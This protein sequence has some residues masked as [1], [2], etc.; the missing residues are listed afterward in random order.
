[1]PDFAFLPRIQVN[2][3]GS[4]LREDLQAEAVAYPLM[5]KQIWQDKIPDFK[6]IDI[7]C[8]LVGSYSNSLHSAG[9]FR[10]WR[11]IDSQAKWLRVH[12]S[13]EWP[14]YYNDA[15]KEDLRSFFDFYLRGVANTWQ[16]TPRVRYA[17]HDFDGNDRVNQISSVFP[18]TG[19][20]Y[21]KYYL[22]GSPLRRLS[23][24]PLAAEIAVQYDTQIY[25]QFAS[26]NMKFTEETVIVGYPKAHLWVE[27]KNANDMDLFV[28]LQKLDARGNHLSQFVVPNQGSIMQDL[29]EQGASIVR[30]KGP[31][32]RL[33]ASVRRLDEELSTDEIPVHSYDTIE[34][35]QPAQIVQL[36]IDLLPMG[37]VYYPGEQL[38]LLVSARNEPGGL[39]PGVAAY[40]PANQGQHIIHTGGSHPSYLQLPV[41]PAADPED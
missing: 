33:R 32:G 41:K 24:D 15:N 39:M 4:G 38:R 13:M 36:D 37:V 29:T 40:V 31:H 21:K 19:V 28:V 9:I 18:P 11:L 30:Y 22:D 3:M 1:M 7:P 12:N 2:Q 20:I 26:F 6:K 10:A 27:V 17:V 8:Y 35:L 34:P 5:N 23:P 25:P 14:D 16:S